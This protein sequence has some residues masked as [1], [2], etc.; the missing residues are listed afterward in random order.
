[1][2]SDFLC[3]LDAFPPIRPA[4]W[5]GPLA[6]SGP[7]MTAKPTAAATATAPCAPP[8]VTANSQ[9]SIWP[10]FEQAV[11]GGDTGR[12]VARLMQRKLLMHVEALSVDEID[13]MAGCQ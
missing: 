2:L 13:L 10:L 5:Q 7:K 8:A 1:M 3:E 12:N 4:D 9:S 6:R 11:G